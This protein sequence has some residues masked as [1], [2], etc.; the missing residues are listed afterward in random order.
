MKEF[1]NEYA[2]LFI[3]YAITG[4]ILFLLCISWGC[5]KQVKPGPQVLPKPTVVISVPKEIKVEPRPT[6]KATPAI[7]EKM[8]SQGY[9]YDRIFLSQKAL[10]AKEIAYW[11][12]EAGI[13]EFEEWV[14][15]LLYEESKLC[16]ELKGDV[17]ED[18]CGQIAP[19]MKSFYR[20][21]REKLFGKHYG[22]EGTIPEEISLAVAAFHYNLVEL[23]K[24]DAREAVRW[25]HHGVKGGETFVEVVANTRAQLYWQAP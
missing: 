15:A 10:V 25:Y 24:Y 4:F 8:R 19:H 12:K 11:C 9:A 1:L 6:L 14:V 3:V 23:S 20:S 18:D 13:P 5:S 22:P 17:G 2:R 21:Y 16:S 7:V